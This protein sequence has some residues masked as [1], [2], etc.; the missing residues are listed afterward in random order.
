MNMEVDEDCTT[1]DWEAVLELDEALAG[2][3]LQGPARGEWGWEWG[4]SASDLQDPDFDAEEVPAVS[5]RTHAS[6]KP[7]V[8]S[9][10]GC[11][12]VRNFEGFR[13]ID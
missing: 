1:S 13:K 10:K 12:V 9:T 4:W 3:L 2:W 11:G 5:V 8:L 6:L 7:G